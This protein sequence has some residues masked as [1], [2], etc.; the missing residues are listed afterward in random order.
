MGNGGLTDPLA[1]LARDG[2]R[3]AMTDGFGDDVL[4]PLYQVED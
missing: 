1:V 3:P 4:A 2:R